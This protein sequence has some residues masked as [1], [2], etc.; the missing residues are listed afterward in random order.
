MTK[1]ARMDNSLQGTTSWHITPNSAA[2]PDYNRS[3]G[4]SSALLFRVRLSPVSGKP[5]GCQMIMH[6]PSDCVAL[7]RWRWCW[8][9][10]Y[11][12]AILSALVLGVCG[13]QLAAHEKSF[14]QL[15]STL[16]TLGLAVPLG[17]W[18]LRRAPFTVRRWVIR[19]V[20]LVWVL[21]TLLIFVTIEQ[22]AFLLRIV[23]WVHAL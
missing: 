23:R 4:V 2:A 22:P 17:V 5:L 14:V 1:V 3:A 19:V 21:S 9:H 8:R 20:L 13:L 12:L 7:N 6:E 18:L 10:D 16:F 11:P 15:G